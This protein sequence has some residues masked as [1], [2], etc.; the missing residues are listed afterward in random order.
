MNKKK[1][2]FKTPY[3]RQQKNMAKRYTDSE[4]WKKDFIKTL[5]TEYKLFWLYLLDECDHAGIWHVELDIAEIR[6]GFKLSLQKIRGLFN[7]KV[8]EFDNGAKWFIPDFI[9]F[10]YGQLDVK[11]K[12]HK[13]VIE[14]LERYVKK[15]L[16]RVI[17]DPMDKDKDKPSLS[18]TGIVF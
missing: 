9:S 4:K 12:A 18:N 8:V 13:S 2:L 10:Q 1:K 7:G 15:G 11:N 3:K 14:K 6:L 17:Q 5:P 16:P